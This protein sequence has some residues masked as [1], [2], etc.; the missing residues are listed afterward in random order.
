MSFKSEKDKQKRNKQDCIEESQQ[1]EEEKIAVA[2]NV[3]DMMKALPAARRCRI[4]KRAKV[5][6]NEE[7]SLQELRTQFLGT[8]KE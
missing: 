7:L 2:R 5:R 1:R 6:M 3:N 4:E 8:V